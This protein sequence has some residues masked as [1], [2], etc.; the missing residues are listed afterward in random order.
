MVVVTGGS[1]HVGANLVR[2][3]HERG[4]PVRAL[5][6]R[7][8][9]AFDGLDI[10][11]ASGDILDSRS[12]VSAFKGADYVYHLAVHISISKRDAAEAALINVQGTRNVVDACREGG[13]RR[14]V[15]FSSIHA[16]S[17]EP[18]D[19]MIDENRPL[20]GASAT[21]YDRS[22]VDAEW[23]VLEAVEK[24]LDA[25]IVN[26]TAILG[27]CD[28]KPSYMGRFLLALYHRD[29]K[30]LVTGGFDW[31]DVR[32]VITGA[33]AAEQRGKRGERYLL[34]GTWLSVPDLAALVEEI[35]GVRA[36][37]FTAP[38]WLAYMGLPFMGA[39][40]RM[41]KSEPLYTKESLH[42]LQNHRFISHDKATRELGY[43][44]RPLQETL[45]DTLEWFDA[46]GYL[47]ERSMLRR[48]WG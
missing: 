26:P 4:R 18:R 10:E 6:H 14:L 27:P 34:S 19:E 13:V 7:D 40:S 9:R 42:A 32:D 47:D 38:M 33:L 20:A 8:R 2:M 16:L 1:G 44:P 46:H 17:S 24:G 29:F 30:S 15:H 41:K 23:I 12:L 31:V 21:V 3:L 11:T 25:I 48:A 36:P 39:L 43:K 28:F 45:R 22:K 35:T 37:W 5:V